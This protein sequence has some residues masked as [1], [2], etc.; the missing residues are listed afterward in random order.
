[1]IIS[2]KLM[3]TH[4]P[5]SLYAIVPAICFGNITKKTSLRL[6][7]SSRMKKTKAQMRLYPARGLSSA[8]GFPQ[9]VIRCLPLKTLL[10]A[11]C[12][13]IILNCANFSSLSSKP[14]SRQVSVYHHQKKSP[15]NRHRNRPYPHLPISC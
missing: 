6:V 5:K 12:L 7:N 1:M 9:Y 2:M 14:S 13:Q 4:M 15:S 3:N 10:S 11:T 8:I